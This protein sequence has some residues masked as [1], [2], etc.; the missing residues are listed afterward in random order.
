MKLNLIYSTGQVAGMLGL[1]EP[2]LNN[3]LRRRA[4]PGVPVGP[5]GRR[6]WTADDIEVTRALLEGRRSRSA[7]GATNAP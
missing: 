4:L 1:T 7:K 5:G 6:L 3:L 2:Q